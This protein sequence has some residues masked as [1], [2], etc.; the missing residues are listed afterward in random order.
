M[1]TDKSIVLFICD[2][3]WLEI[4]EQAHLLRKEHLHNTKKSVVEQVQTQR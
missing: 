1:R 3:L 4:Y 2:H